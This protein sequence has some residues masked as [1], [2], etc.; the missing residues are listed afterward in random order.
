MDCVKVVGINDIE[1]VRELKKV[2]ISESMKFVI[3]DSLMLNMNILFHY[4]K[5]K[6]NKH[7][8]FRKNDEELDLIA[9][10][11]FATYIQKYYLHLS[12]NFLITFENFID[13]E[14]YIILG[15]RNYL[16][17]CY[18]NK[19]EPMWN[20]N[21]LKKEKLKIERF[22]HLYK[23]KTFEYLVK[24][25]EEIPYTKFNFPYDGKID[26]FVFY[27]N[28]YSKE[29][30]NK[31]VEIMNNL[32]K[33]ENY[34]P[35]FEKA[36]IKIKELISTNKINDETYFYAIGLSYQNDKLDRIT[37]Y[38]WFANSILI[39]GGIKEFIK[40]K[41]KTDITEEIK[42]PWYYAIDF[43]EDK[44]DVKI[45]DEPHIF[46]EKI[47]DEILNK[48][49]YNKEIV[50]VLKYRNNTK[51]DEKYE[52]EFNKIFTDEEKLIL[53]KK[54]LFDKQ[55]KVLAIYIQNGEII[56]HTMYNI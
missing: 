49:L 31:G 54:K 22:K 14:L 56:K 18:H 38:T 8:I 43:Y 29:L 28:C 45:Y 21:F 1:F 24:K 4:L 2:K 15:E 53:K 37:L 26:R 10:R 36:Y 42:N 48:V 41:H 20:E 39:K 17:Y 47:N 34:N 51:I 32:E 50:R 6:N 7:I 9:L 46:K 35:R 16:N 52:F 27:L 44:E 25:Q 3:N 13:G 11:K 33:I 30:Q 19:I 40:R 55:Y 23:Y 5:M 12:N